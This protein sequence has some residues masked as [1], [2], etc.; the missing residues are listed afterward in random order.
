MIRMADIQL[1]VASTYGVSVADLKE[2]DGFGTRM[3]S[4][5]RP[6]QLAMFLARTHCFSLNYGDGTRP[7]SL[8][9]I[10]RSFGNRDHTTVRHAIISI[11]EERLKNKF[12]STIIGNLERQ[13]L[14][15]DKL[16]TAA[17]PMTA[18]SA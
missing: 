11:A 4:K 5:V 14:V 15:V 12:L 7:I 10:G 6:R 8:T 2:P 1:A 17:F 9:Q 18:A 3:P 16:H 13:L